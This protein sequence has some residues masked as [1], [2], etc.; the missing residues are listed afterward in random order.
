[1]RKLEERVMQ[2]LASE[3]VVLRRRFADRIRKDTVALSNSLGNKVFLGVIDN[4]DPVVLADADADLLAVSDMSRDG[5][6]PDVTPCVQAGI[7]QSDDRKIIVLD[8]ERG[9]KRPYFLSDI[10]LCPG[11]FYVRSGSRYAPATLESIESMIRESDGASYE[12]CRSTNQ[13]LTFETAKRLLDKENIVFQE[14]QLLRYGLINSDRLFTNLGLLLSDQCV[15][16]IRVRGYQ[17]STVQ[18]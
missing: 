16:T 17:H 10:G 12:R 11:G 14:S 8:V 2:L 9:V 7:D 1:M 15:H 13:A 18:S 3:T 4:G 5:I 6:K